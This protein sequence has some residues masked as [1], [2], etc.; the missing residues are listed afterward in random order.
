MMNY[1]WSGM[2]L[3]SL[4]I[5]MWNG[6]LDATMQAAFE[7]ANNAIATVLG[8]IGVTA[9]W[10]GL[11]RIAEK[12]GLVRVFSRIIRPLGR[13][14][15]PNLPPDSAAF[16][17][18]SMNMVANILG[19]AN[20]ATPLGL[21]A[22]RELQ[23]RNHSPNRASDEMCT[24][25]VLNT[26]SIQLIPSTLIGIRASFGSAAP[27]EIILPVWVV[28]LLTA[29]VGLTITHWCNKRSGVRHA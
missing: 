14:I 23:K 4:M 29:T 16:S 1:I 3:L 12:S 28:S 21:T 7:S 24:F 9:L 6:R 22:M 2:M 26:A 8:F 20:A 18:I 10:T 13:L 19:L 15:F 25:V 11:M 5:A 27:S 17:A